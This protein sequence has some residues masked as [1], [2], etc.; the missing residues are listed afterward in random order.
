[1]VGILILNYN[2]TNDIK[3]C[4]ESV[5]RYCDMAKIKIMVVDNGSSADIF[6]EVQNYLQGL[7]DNDLD[8]ISSD[9]SVKRL[10]KVTYLRLI[11]NIGYARGN[12]AGLKFIFGDD[13]IND[14]L[15]L[16]SDIVLTNNLLEPLLAEREKLENVGAISPLLV[17][18]NNKV[19]YSCARMN[20]ST[21]CLSLTFSYLFAKKYYKLRKQSDLLL[22]SPEL[23]EK[24]NFEIELPSGSCMLV[25]KNV[26]Y[27]IGGFDDNTFLYYEENILYEKFKKLNLKNYIVPSVSCIH[28]G[29]ATTNKT[30][31]SLFLKDCNYKSLI[32][33]LRTY[34]DIG[35]VMMFYIHLSAKIRLFKMRLNKLFE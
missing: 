2:N 5:C 23:L 27:Q 32:Y 26:F 34:R 31:S 19:D 11:K 16:N 8:V 22:N 4:I 15:V 24:S 10:K 20:Y 21:H 14:V 28:V 6:I 30:K 17:H 9:S 13:D 12:N 7:F 3:R 1:M 33:Y 18:P 35:Y 25:R 29:G